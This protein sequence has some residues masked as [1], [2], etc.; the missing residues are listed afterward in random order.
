[1][2][3]WIPAAIAAAGSLISS[4]WT[5][6]S[7]KRN[8]EKTNQQQVELMREQNA[9]NESMM[10]KQNE[11][12]SLPNQVKQMQE[13]GLNP[14]FMFQSGGTAQGVSPASSAGLAQLTPPQANGSGIAEA[15]Y[16]SVELRNQTMK[17]EA[18]VNEQTA[19]TEGMKT[20]NEY[21]DERERSLIDQIKANTSLSDAER[22]LRI[23]QV[24]TEKASYINMMQSVENMKY[25]QQLLEEKLKTAPYERHMLMVEIIRKT[26]LLPYEIQE[27]ASRANLNKVEAKLAFMTVNK[28]RDEC[29]NLI[30]QGKLIDQNIISQIIDNAV[31][32]SDADV[33]ISN[34]SYLADSPMRS[35]IYS[36]CD[37]I[38][39]NMFKS[40]GAT[41]YGTS[42]FTRFRNSERRAYEDYVKTPY[43]SSWANP[44]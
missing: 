1:M 33:K 35:F 40:I 14:S 8:V 43:A 39:G 3:E 16:R 23:Q 36:Q 24:Q 15:F 9:F 34:N 26:K 44:Q 25:E 19:H 13:A 10:S 22:D 18:D 6:Q 2:Y 7:N 38:I 4:I 21:A 42:P 17:A 5:N 27:S 30:K 32:R 11:I 20:A 41:L 12:N 37:G 31:K 29:L 28:V